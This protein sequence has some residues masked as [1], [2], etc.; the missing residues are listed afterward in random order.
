MIHTI[1]AENLNSKAL[2]ARLGSR[3]L[4]RGRL[5][6]PWDLELEIWGQTKDE[7]RAR[8]TRRL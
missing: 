7:W 6:A 5:P 8:T 2:A 4:R 1:A 3:Y